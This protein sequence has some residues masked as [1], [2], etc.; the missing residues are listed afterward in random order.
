MHAV[1]A[2]ALVAT[3][4]ACKGREAPA[5]LPVEP[6][7]GR[8]AAAPVVAPAPAA[9]AAPSK[10]G[11]YARLPRRPP[12][13]V[14]TELGRKLFLDESLSASGKLACRSC[15]D[16]GRAMAPANDR[17]IQRGGADGKQVGFRAA[18]S[19]RY[20]ASVRPFTEHDIDDET[21]ADNGP[22]GGFMWDG[23]AAT[24]HD[25]A[26][27][28]L[29]APFEMA[30]ESSAAL[31][32]RLRR[33]PYAGELRA[34]FGDTA[35]DDDDTAV[36]V[37]AFALEVFGQ[38]PADFAPFTSKYDAVLRGQA[39]LSASELRGFRLFNAPDKGNCASCHPSANEHGGPPLF[40]DF[41]FVALGVPRTRAIAAN[42]D[43]SFYDL[44]LCGP[45]RTD[46][47]ERPEYCGLFRTP[48]LRNVALRRRLFHNGS[49]TSLARAV[50]FYAT[51]DV[52]PA[53]WYPR[54][55]QGR[56]QKFDDLPGRYR[57]NVNMDPPFGGE[58]G[59]RPALD[60]AEIADIVA[61]LGTLT[62][63]YHPR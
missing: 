10:P 4:L 24:A 18:P 32:A 11:F 42:A 1:R 12:P 30:N 27:L 62:D 36:A 22:A 39:Q 53:T 9:S 34:A 59:G 6:V 61:F 28:P 14:T 23:R 38:S 37:A 51:R 46:L 48:S 7:V 40:S 41:G 15:H 17:A 26:R 33:A 2:L 47:A 25:Q 16:P 5:P 43:P 63:G 8:D 54:D 29:F 3:C 57:A 56:V 13:A 31:A 49:F 50:R 55:V 20:L 19:L 44:G 58:P 52:A 21:G 60:E 45:L 35:L